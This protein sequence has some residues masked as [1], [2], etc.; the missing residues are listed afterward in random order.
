MVSIFGIVF[1]LTVLANIYNKIS[2]ELILISGCLSIV[3]IFFSDGGLDYKNYF[4]N[5][6]FAILGKENLIFE[7]FYQKFIEIFSNL[8][9]YKEFRYFI[10]SGLIGTFTFL[11]YKSDYPN[12]LLM[13]L[14]L[15][16]GLYF[17]QDRQIIATSILLVAA[18]KRVNI[19]TFIIVSLMA[20]FIHRPSII[21][22][23][24]FL[25]S[26]FFFLEGLKKSQIVFFV[27]SMM[28]I[29]L[30]LPKEL[31]SHYFSY[32]MFE[33]DKELSISIGK[34]RKI[35]EILAILS[36]T[37]YSLK[38]LEFNNL[39]KSKIYSLVIVLVMGFFSTFLEIFTPKVQR[40]ENYLVYMP[41]L[42]LIL[43]INYKSFK[44]N[45]VISCYVFI[46][47]TYKV[48]F[49]EFPL[50]IE[51]LNLDIYSFDIAYVF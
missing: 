51:K 32:L 21:F 40:V 44:L 30:L 16:M 36:F 49:G 1:I 46:L 19:S 18:Y 41:I 7:P 13:Y 38:N 48:I 17:G 37:F 2:K 29:L 9:T 10:Y 31:V 39:E 28:I 4:D 34:I 22:S 15:I 25:S 50:L 26:Y 6:S 33:E 45:I 24:I 27:I 5:Y 8:I 20:F 43:S 3:L 12:G 23:I 35:F 47:F 11:A 14:C 42:L